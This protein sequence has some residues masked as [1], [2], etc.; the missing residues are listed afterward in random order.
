[1]INQ[2]QTIKAFVAENAQGMDADTQQYIARAL[3]AAVTLERGNSNE[4]EETRSVSLKED[5]DGKVTAKSLKLFNLMKVSYYDLFGFLAE[6]III[7]L[8]E[9]SRTKIITSLFKLFYSFYPKLTYTFNDTDAKILMAIWQMNKQKWTADEVLD[10]YTQKNTPSVSTEQI[11]RSLNFLNELRVVKY[12]G[13]GVYEQR[14]KVTY[15]RH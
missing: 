1:M 8:T 2:E 9:D 12:L 11:Q 6:E 13:K 10:A 4:A 14:E 15:E 7:A 5:T 3:N